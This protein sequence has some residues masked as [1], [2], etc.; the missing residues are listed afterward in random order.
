[1][2][3]ADGQAFIIGKV[4][5]KPAIVKVDEQGQVLFEKGIDIARWGICLD[6]VRL[7]ENRFRICG[8]TK[9]DDSI[10]SWVVDVDDQGEMQREFVIDNAPWIS[11]A[12]NLRIARLGSNWTAFVHPVTADGRTYCYVTALDD[13]LRRIDEV[14]LCEVPRYGGTLHVQSYGD[15]LVITVESSPRA[16][17]VYMV[18]ENLKVKAQGVA[19]PLSVGSP[20]ISRL[21]VSQNR[22][23]VLAQKGTPLQKE[24][25]AIGCV[26]LDLR[27]SRGQVPP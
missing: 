24:K 27:D 9:E 6:G 23:L 2:P 19:E 8:V 4:R 21:A 5:G 20:V 1:M 18:D 17:S 14:R 13:A 22:A 7:S 10:R 12:G 11:L 25:H 3:A 26:V 15:G 16:I